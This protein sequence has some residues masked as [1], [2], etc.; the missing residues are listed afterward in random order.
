MPRRGNREPLPKYSFITVEPKENDVSWL[1]VHSGSLRRH[2]AY[3]GG[4][5]KFQGEDE[6]NSVGRHDDVITIESDADEG[7]GAATRQPSSK[8]YRIWF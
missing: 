6:R 5:A 4:P 1:K 3:W 7:A 2:A 8:M